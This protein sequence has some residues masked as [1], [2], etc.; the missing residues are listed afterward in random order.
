MFRDSFD[1][2][3]LP[4]A[5]VDV[6]VSTPAGDGITLQRTLSLVKHT[7]VASTPK[8]HPVLKPCTAPAKKRSGKGK[9]VATACSGTR[10]VGQ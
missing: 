5:I 4:D 7:A 3:G 6:I 2:A 10:N 8:A 9:S 1:F